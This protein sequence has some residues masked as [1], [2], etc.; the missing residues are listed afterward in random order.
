M[1]RAGGRIL[2]V[3]ADGAGGTGGG[4]L[5][6][7]AVCDAAIAAFRGTAADSWD[8]HLARIDAEL[9]RTRHGGLSTAVVVEIANGH[10]AGASVG[11]S[12]AWLLTSEGVLDLTAQQVRKPLMGSASAKPVTFGPQP[13]HGRLLVGTDGLFKYATRAQIAA[14]ASVTDTELAAAALVNAVR[15]PDGRLQDDVAVVI[16]GAA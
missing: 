3:V 2:I 7:D 4:A 12:A 15:M 16:C 11:D 14:A 10:L 1:E 8:R 13:L 5:A 9:S 6:A